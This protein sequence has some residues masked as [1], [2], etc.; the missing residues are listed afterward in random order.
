MGDRA[1]AHYLGAEIQQLRNDLG[2]K[3]QT[4]DAKVEVLRAEL[5]GRMDGMEGRLD[6]RMDALG[7]KIDAVGR[8]LTFMLAGFG[9]LQ[10][11]LIVASGMGVFERTPVGSYPVSEAACPWPAVAP[12]THQAPV[13]RGGN[14]PPP[15]THPAR[16]R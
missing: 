4:L 5:S 13:A 10:G 7:R 9:L 2:L 14:G 6:G 1:D 8:K 11:V 16:P 3:I 15:G 12:H